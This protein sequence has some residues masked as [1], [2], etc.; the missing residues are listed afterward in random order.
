MA[1]VKKA[2]VEQAILEAAYRLFAQQGYAGTRMPQIAKAAGISPSTIY[3]YFS[4]KFQILSSLYVPWFEQRLEALETSLKRCRTAP[5]KLRRIVTAMWS[6]LPAADNGFCSN[7]IQ[8]L[9]ERP[10]D[11]YRPH[12]RI[13]IEERLSV[14][15]TGSLPELTAPQSRYIANFILMA[16]DG[17][18]LNFTLQN[19]KTASAAEIKF[20][21]DM[22]LAYARGAGAAAKTATR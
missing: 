15:L 14:M 5:Q 1:Q 11:E 12:L 21:C 16:F 7:L 17:Y 3:V 9:S 8:A 13:Y 19:G 6:E 22:I 20:L 2:E 4:S 18:A 10:E